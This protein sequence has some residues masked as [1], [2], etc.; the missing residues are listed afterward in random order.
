MALAVPLCRDMS[1]SPSSSSSVKDERSCS[2]MSMGKSRY[3]SILRRGSFASF[4]VELAGGISPRASCCAASYSNDLSRPWRTSLQNAQSDDDDDAV[5]SLRDEYHGISHDNC[6]SFDFFQRE[7]PCWRMSWRGM[8]LQRAQRGCMVDKE[9]TDLGG[10]VYKS[11]YMK[12]HTNP[13]CPSYPSY[14]APISSKLMKEERLYASQRLNLRTLSLYM[15]PK[16]PLFPLRL[17]PISHRSCTCLLPQRSENKQRSPPS[18]NR[19]DHRRNHEDGKP[20]HDMVARRVH[21]AVH[22]TNG[23]IGP[24]QENVRLVILAGQCQYEGY[25]VKLGW[26]FHE[27]VVIVCLPS[28][29]SRRH[30]IEFA[31]R[32]GIF[33]IHLGVYWDPC[34]VHPG[35]HDEGPDIEGDDGCQEGRYLSGRH[36]WLGIGATCIAR[37]RCDLNSSISKK[38]VWAEETFIYS[39]HGFNLLSSESVSHLI[40]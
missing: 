7:W 29:T 9:R 31:L 4:S 2:D 12:F 23:H 39:N 28:D 11:S 21:Q 14:P 36:L 34:L 25:R 1:Q 10:Q 32:D 24:C 35:L 22:N 6:G 40:R 30:R 15:F 33:H 3:P 20:A 17:P 19:Q 13:I 8:V 37:R 5:N 16:G 26:L 18:H 27:M 38:K